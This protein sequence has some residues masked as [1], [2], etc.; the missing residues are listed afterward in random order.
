M[1]N[2]ESGDTVRVCY[3]GR[4][5][6]GPVLDA[7]HETDAYQFTI[8]DGRVLPGFE[9]AVIGMTPGQ[10]KRVVVRAEE[11]FGRRRDDMVV[12]IGRD[13][14]PDE[15]DLELGKKLQAHRPDGGT[16]RVTVTL[17]TDTEVTLD[18]NHPLAGKDLEYDIR[19][20]EIV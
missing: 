13:Q 10:N 2:A 15:V 19:L 11:A 3:T 12:T 14:V 5:V 20:L 1:P 16:V 7:R 18:A 4:I 9:K 17:L 8:G 6:E